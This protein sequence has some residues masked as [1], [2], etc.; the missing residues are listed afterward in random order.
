MGNGLPARVLDPHLSPPPGGLLFLLLCWAA[1]SSPTPSHGVSTV[2]LPLSLPPLLLPPPS[3]CHTA[4]E[5]LLPPADLTGSSSRVSIVVAWPGPDH[6][7]CSLVP[8][9]PHPH[10]PY[11]LGVP[12]S[13][14]RK[15]P[16]LHLWVFCGNYPSLRSSLPPLRPNTELM[17]P[18]TP[19]SSLAVPASL[20]GTTGDGRFPR[21]RDWGSFAASPCYL[22]S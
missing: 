1:F 13:I 6:Y 14:F 15:I 22:T 11:S 16:H 19:T 8:P 5:S 21:G 2:S 3:L 17:L 9:H 20:P 12:Q 7:T 10:P 4:R 18:P